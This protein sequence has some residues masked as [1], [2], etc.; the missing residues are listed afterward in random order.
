[1]KKFKLY[2]KNSTRIS[3]LI[4]AG[5]LS[6]TSIT[7]CS[8]EDN[9]QDDISVES[10]YSNA[11]ESFVDNSIDDSLINNRAGIASLFPT[12]SKDIVNNSS[13]ILLLDEIAKED[14]NSKINADVISK[15]KSKINSNDMMNDF[16][17]FLDVL[18]QNMINSNN[19]LETNELVIEKDRVIIS[20]LEEITNNIMNGTK[21]D[22]KF[23]FNFM[24][25]LF[26]L[27]DEIDYGGVNFKIRDLSYSSRALAGSYARVSAY[28]ARNY[29]TDEEYSKIDDRT[30]DQNNKAYIKTKLEI[31]S[32]DMEEVSIVDVNALFTQEYKNTN[33]IL[34]NKVN[35]EEDNI[36]NLVNYINLEYLDSDMV[37][38]KDKNT[39][40]DG[41]TD[42]KVYNTLLAIDAITEYNSNNKN[43]LIV[44][45]NI[46]VSEYEFT[47]NGKIDKVVLDYIQFNSVMLL[48]TTTEN[49]TKEEIFNNP[50]FKNIYKYFTK[51]DFVHKYNENNIVSINY[52]DISEG[53]KFIANE[54]VL[55]TINKRPN[56]KE[57]QGYE[58]KIFTNLEESIQ[59]I[60]N[61]ITGECEKV[62]VEEFVKV[63]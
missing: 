19:I 35:V 38:N 28:Y 7:G 25:S 61:T 31:L 34:S 29:I 26:V 45:S 15:Y 55:Y 46:L 11:E 24:Y 30:N 9:N 33:K 48:N 22:I 49:S 21:E 2:K 14:E 40:L 42:E 58:E 5:F 63:K 17:S 16:N 13:L 6:I 56:I 27:E 12:I 59:Y 4:M 3:A 53:A 54:I 52:Q 47:D 18:E 51:Q 36:K 8:K 20:I 50:Y 10:T 37:A 57:Y 60:Q 43:D 41:Y 32:N 1:M 23:N 39:I 44:L 62:D